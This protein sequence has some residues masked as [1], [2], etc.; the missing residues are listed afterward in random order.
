MIII[1]CDYHP[2]FQTVAVYDSQSEQ[3]RVLW[4]SHGNGEAERFYRALTE[5]ALIGIESCG[6]TLWFERLVVGLG[7]QLKIGDAATIRLLAG[8]DP[9]TDPRDAR[10][11]LALLR[12]GRFPAIERPT[13]EQR[14]VRQL[15]LHRHKLVQMRTQVMN[16]LQHL[17]LNQGLQLRRKLWTKAGQAQFQAL[18]LDPWAAQRRRDLDQ[19]RQELNGKIAPLTEAIEQQARQRAEVRLLRTHP[20]VGPITALAFVLTVLRVERF[21]HSKQLAS[22]LGLVP[23]ERSSGGRQRLG[24]ITKQGN[25]MLRALLVEAAQTAARLDPELRQDYTR[26]AHKKNRA[27]AKVMVARKLA[28]RLYWMLKT[29]QPYV[30]VSSH[31]GQPESSRGRSK[32]PCA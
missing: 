8:R 25:P 20:G 18:V 29:Q 32:R 7:H 14:D 28:V 26:L 23:R 6:N 16:E 27:I 19:L 24:A 22:Y 1:G 9:K 10:H 31:A 30:R 5:P 21:R 12:D 3:T 15:L 11:I 4:L 2:S 17:A 13:L